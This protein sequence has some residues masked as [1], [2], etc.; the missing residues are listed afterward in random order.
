[1]EKTHFF[2]GA[3]A[4]V[5]AGRVLMIIGSILFFIVAFSRLLEFAISFVQIEGVDPVNW[6]DP[7]QVFVVVADPFIAV[8]YVLAGIGGLC[9]VKDKHRLRVFA[10][11]AGVIMLV[12]ILVAT[13][14]MF[15]N[16]IKS[17]LAPNA[18][19]VKAWTDFLLDFIGIQVTGG[20]YFI[21]WFLTKDYTGD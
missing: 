1:M 6:S 12:V 21:G 5:K 19:L 15:R 18:N 20:I 7:Y 8:L 4:T 14:L 3:P 2:A 13:V 10:S 17:C 11:L 16:L 9:Y